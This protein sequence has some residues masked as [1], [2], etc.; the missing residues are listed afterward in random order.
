MVAFAGVDAPSAADALRGQVLLAPSRSTTPEALWVHEL[1]G[2]RG[3]RRRRHRARHRGGASRPTRPATSWSSTTGGLIPLRFVVEPRARASGSPSTCPTACSTWPERGHRVRI[4]VFTIFPD[5][6]DAYCAA[7]RS[8]AGPGRA[9]CSTCGSTTCAPGP[10]DPRRS[11]DDAP[12]AAGRAWCWLPSR[13]SAPSRRWTPPSGLPRPLLLWRPAGRRFDQA[14]AAELAGVAEG[15]SLLCGRYEG[16]DQRV[17]DHLVDGELSIGDYVLAGARWP[18][19]WSSRRWPAWCPGSWATRPRPTTRASATACSST[20]STPG[21][22][23]S[24]AGRFPR[25]CVR[26]TTAGSPA[27][28]GPRP[29]PAPSSAVRTWSRTAGG[30]SPEEVGLLAELGEVRLL[31]R[32][33][34]R[35]C[36]PRRGRRAG[37]RVGRP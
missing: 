8:S 23:S 26:A 11:V 20:R 32:A 34:L 15:F 22:P 14:V 5:L 35:L 19:W 21:R 24:G 16:V 12:S 18:P 28:A 9:A 4:D 17:A 36:E 7:S 33:R 31:A 10:T 27:G 29:W 6:V 37:L 25:C 13:S 1:V 3:G 2:A 30:L